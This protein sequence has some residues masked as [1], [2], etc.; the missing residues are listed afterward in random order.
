[1]ELN[2][3]SLYNEIFEDTQNKNYKSTN[4]KNSGNKILISKIDLEDSSIKNNFN[5]INDNLNINDFLNS[6]SERKLLT[7]NITSSFND[8]KD[9]NKIKKDK[10]IFDSS[11][12]SNVKMNEKF[13]LKIVNKQEQKNKK[14]NSKELISEKSEKEYKLDEML[15]IISANKK[16]CIIKKGNPSFQEDSKDNELTHKEIQNSKSKN[17]SAKK[18]KTN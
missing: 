1:M 15:E 7:D 6:N 16:F 2:N 11:K 10:L 3:E 12:L 13:V 9:D 8:S 4:N 5:N 14:E 18:E 17:N